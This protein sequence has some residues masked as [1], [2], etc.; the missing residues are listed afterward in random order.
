MK[1]DIYLRV[2][3]TPSENSIVSRRTFSVWERLLS[4]FLG[5]KR[6]VTVLIPGNTVETMIITETL[7]EEEANGQEEADPEFC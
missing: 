4:K 1:H 3:K 2:S 5:N 7:P 6:N